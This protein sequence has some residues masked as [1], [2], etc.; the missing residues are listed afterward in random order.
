MD[1]KFVD[2]ANSQIHLTEVCQ[3]CCSRLGLGVNAVACAN[4]R[5]K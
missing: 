4:G 3:G 5:G 1:S 2:Q